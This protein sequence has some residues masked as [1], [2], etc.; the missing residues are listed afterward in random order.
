MINSF[1]QL[2]L[3]FFILLS[4]LGFCLYPVFFSFYLLIPSC[5]F[6]CLPLMLKKMQVAAIWRS[7]LREL[8]RAGKALHLN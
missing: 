3:C 7:P 8:I 4:T 6:F 2:M 1:R 5:F